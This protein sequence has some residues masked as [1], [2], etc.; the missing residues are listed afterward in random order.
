[1]LN[2]NHTYNTRPATYHFLDISQ[3]KATHFGEYSV[4]FQASK[5]WSNLQRAQNLEFLTSKP[6]EFKK[7]HILAN[8][9]NST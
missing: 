8:Y 6:S 2:L 1:M 5:T 7:A 3:V 9:S 4:T